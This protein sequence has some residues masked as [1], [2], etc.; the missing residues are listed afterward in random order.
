MGFD[1]PGKDSQVT[2]NE[3]PVNQNIISPRRG[4]HMNVGI[5]VSGIILHN[6]IFPD[7]ILPQNLPK[8]GLCIRPVR[9]RCVEEYDLL[10]RDMTDLI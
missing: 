1:K 4:S 10:L 5:L 7:N 2:F 9:S 3:L 6:T 8:F